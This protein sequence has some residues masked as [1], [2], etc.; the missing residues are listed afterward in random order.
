MMVPLDV[1]L[2]LQ[3]CPFVFYRFMGLE[4]G[5][6]GL[7][8]ADIAAMT[9]VLNHAIDRAR[10]PHFVTQFGGSRIAGK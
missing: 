8:C 7:P 5:R 1:L 2:P 4:I 3:I 6:V 10:I 9:F